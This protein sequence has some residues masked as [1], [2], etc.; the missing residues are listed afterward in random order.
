M[1]ASLTGYG[2]ADF[3]D[4]RG[5]ISAEIKSVN[6]RFLQLD[7]YLPFGYNWLDAPLRSMISE[8]VFR[9]KVVFRLE[10][11]DYAPNQEI[12]VNKTLLTKL[13][14]LQEEI[15]NETGHRIPV[16]LDGLL[17]LPGVLKSEVSEGENEALLARVRPVVQK[18]LTDFLTFR[19]DEGKKLAEDLLKRREMLAA[20]LKAVVDRVPQFREKFL[21]RFTARIKE[22][23]REV[24]VDE[25]RLN[26]EIAIW[27][28]RSDITEELTRLNSHI[29][30]LG[31]ILTS[32]GQIGRKLDFLIQELN[33]EAN[34]ICNK[35]GDLMIVQQMVEMKCE[36]EKIREQ[37]QNIE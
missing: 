25:A 7:I 9:G 36:L 3:S 6:N 32:K 27:A 16:S 18:A 1:V 15:E 33:R 24:G 4:S 12:F 35:I 8:K 17:S 22:L 5:K 20:L 26:T 37:A 14:K 10:L 21:E 29:D 23:T 28:D 34:T 11:F 19:N 2:R 30:E 13:L 31:K